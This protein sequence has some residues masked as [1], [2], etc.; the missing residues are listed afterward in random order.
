[1]VQNFTMKP[2]KDNFRVASDGM[3]MLHF[4]ANTIVENIKA[5]SGQISRHKFDFFDFDKLHLRV[6]NDNILTGVVYSLMYLP[7]KFHLIPI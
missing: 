5:N 2:N 4:H 6:G 1:M 3:T 7:S